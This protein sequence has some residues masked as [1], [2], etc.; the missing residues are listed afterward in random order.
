VRR[1]LALPG[2]TSRPRVNG[3][4]ICFGAGCGLQGMPAGSARACRDCFVLRKVQPTARPEGLAGTAYAPVA[5]ITDGGDGRLPAPG[6]LCTG[7]IWLPPAGQEQEKGPAGTAPP[8]QC[9][10]KQPRLQ[11]KRRRG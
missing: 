4:L 1:T 6:N 11:L 2:G 8:G 5:V 7:F 10:A 3:F 9:G